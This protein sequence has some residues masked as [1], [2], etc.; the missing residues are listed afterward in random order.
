MKEVREKSNFPFFVFTKKYQ[1]KRKHSGLTCNHSITFVKKIWK[2]VSDLI[3]LAKCFIQLYK[4]ILKGNTKYWQI[5]CTGFD[6]QIQ[7]V[8]HP[9]QQIVKMIVPKHNNK[10]WLLHGMEIYWQ[11]KVHYQLYSCQSTLNLAVG[12]NNIKVMFFKTT[13]RKADLPLHKPYS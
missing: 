6:H 12:K 5:F 8:H 11:G 2:I 13:Y 1:H 10:I 9:E 4:N 7:R 3:I